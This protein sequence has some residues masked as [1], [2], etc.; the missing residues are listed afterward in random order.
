MPNRDTLYSFGWGGNHGDDFSV[1]LFIDLIESEDILSFIEK[2]EESE[3]KHNG[4]KATAMNLIFGDNKGNIGYQLSVAMPRRKDQSP[5]LGCRVLN[6]RTSAY[7]WSGN[8]VPLRELP[9]SINPKRGYICNANNRQAPE[10]VLKDYGATQM[11]TG[12]SVRIEEMIVEGITL[13]KKFTAE[14]MVTMMQDT[15][16]VQ[17]RRVKP[18]LL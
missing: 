4:Y 6:G 13:G 17:A 7:D 10:N 11:S 5:Y 12:R 9:R 2:V 18:A 16:D 1:D 8:L 3:R 15:I 14:D